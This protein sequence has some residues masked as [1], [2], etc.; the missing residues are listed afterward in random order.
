MMGPTTPPETGFSRNTSPA[1]TVGGLGFEP[2][3]RAPDTGW[4]FVPYG[5]WVCFQCGERFT[6]VSAAGAHFGSRP[7]IPP[8][9]RPL[10]ALEHSAYLRGMRATLRLLERET[11]LATGSIAKVRELIAAVEP[12]A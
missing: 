2:D 4:N 1:F 9:C 7:E 10:G 8:E 6:S 3:P 5:G 11:P 12:R